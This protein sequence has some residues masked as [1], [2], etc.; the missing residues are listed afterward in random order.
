MLSSCCFSRLFFLENVE[1]VELLSHFVLHFVVVK[2]PGE[3]AKAEDKECHNAPD[4]SKGRVEL[5]IFEGV[6]LDQVAIGK[7]QVVA[8]A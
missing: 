4:D 5:L 2:R 8:H 6:I 1:E 7:R 3:K